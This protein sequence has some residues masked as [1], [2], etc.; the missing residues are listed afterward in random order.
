MYFHVSSY[1]H[2]GDILTHQTKYNPDTCERISKAHISNYK[3]YLSLLN[4]L[5]E[6]KI[7]D[8][9]GR[10]HYKWSCEA[11]FESVRVEYYPDRPSRIWG[12]YLVDSFQKAQEF[13]KNFRQGTAGIFEIDVS[14]KDVYRFDM[15][16]FTNVDEALRADHSL[17]NYIKAVEIAHK[18]WNGI[19]ES[20]TIECLIDTDITVGRKIS[21]R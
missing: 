6:E 9:T 4:S 7:C 21:Y 3:D 16:M 8:K 18:Y 17:G 10:D 19:I 11:I 1:V 13:C 2:E 12:I 15:D 20:N 5:E 14:E